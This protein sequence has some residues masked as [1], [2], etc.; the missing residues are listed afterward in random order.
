MLGV[1]QGAYRKVCLFM[2]RCLIFKSRVGRR[3]PSLAAAP[4]GP[5]TFPLSAR[6]A[7]MEFFVVDPIVPP[8]D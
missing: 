2:L 8:L 7:W 5:A 6:A 1:E 4:F 3:I